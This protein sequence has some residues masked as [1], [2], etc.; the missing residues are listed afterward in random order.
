MKIENTPLRC[1]KA[2]ILVQALTYSTMSSETYWD[3]H[4]VPPRANLVGFVVNKLAPAQVFFETFG[5]SLSGI[6]ASATHSN[7]PIIDATY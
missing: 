5:F 7:P 1:N 4:N 2:L 6:I 3:G